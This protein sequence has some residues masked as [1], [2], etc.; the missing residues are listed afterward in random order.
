MIATIIIFLVAIII[1]FGMLMFRAWE[2]KTSRVERPLSTTNI[3]PEI[4]FRQ[5]EKI[6]LYLAKHVIQWIVLVTVKYWFILI[7]KTKKWISN[8]S[9]RIHNFLKKKVKDVSLQNDT[10]VSRAI[11]ESKIKIKRMKERIKKD[12]EEKSS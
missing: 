4:Y 10:F 6:M 9:P 12:H 2:I 11:L 5:V 7:T 3:F 8:N 1:L